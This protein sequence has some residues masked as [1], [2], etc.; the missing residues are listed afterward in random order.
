MKRISVV[1]LFLVFALCTPCARSAEPVD[2]IYI[3]GVNAYDTDEVYEEAAGLNKAFAGQMLGEDYYFSGV[4]KVVIWSD[5]LKG[6]LPYEIYSSGLISLNTEY[7]KSKN[8]STTDFDGKLLNPLLPLISVSDS[9]SGGYAVYLRNL[10]NDFL[11]QVFIMKD[12]Q[13]KQEILMERIASAAGALEGKFVIVAHSYGAVAALDFAER[14]IMNDE[15]LSERF[16]G[17]ITSADVNSTFNAYKWAEM[18]ASGKGDNFMKYFVENDKFWICYNHRNDMAASNL[19]DFV[20]NYK[21]TGNGF[22]VNGTT[23]SNYARRLNPF[24]FDNGKISAHLWMVR[25]Q[26]D[27]VK[28]VVCLYDEVVSNRKNK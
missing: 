8:K 20:L 23:K 16:A 24:G 14:H 12:S 26:K 25:Q 10:I 6:D 5:L 21:A 27:F 22:I 11:Y 28:K 13:E 4:Y 19:P 17:M 2:I 7:N 18:V 9:G 1:F 3:H 15:R